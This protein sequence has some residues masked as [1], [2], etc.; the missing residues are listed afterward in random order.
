MLEAAT[1]TVG[2]TTGSNHSILFSCA[3]KTETIKPFAKRES[4]FCGWLFAFF[5]RTMMI[6]GQR[7]EHRKKDTTS[8][9]VYM[10]KR[11]LLGALSLLLALVMLTMVGCGTSNPSDT[12][13]WFSKS[14]TEFI[15][16][17]EDEYNLNEAGSYWYFTAAKDTEVTMNLIIGVDHYTSAAYLYVNDTQVQSETNTGIYTY[18][19]KLSLKKGDEIKIHAFW[20]NSL[21]TSKTGFDLHQISMSQDGKTYILTE[22]D[23][24]K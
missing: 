14:S 18:V 15:A 3:H 5:K 10:N 9:E 17:D 6:G 12:K 23:K 24:L 2:I 22:F 21:Y 7:S 4:A 16:F 20:V 13:Y 8:Q 11:F 1:N 19:Y